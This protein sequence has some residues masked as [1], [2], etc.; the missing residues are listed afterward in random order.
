MPWFTTLIFLLFFFFLITMRNKD[1]GIDREGL[2]KQQES[3]RES[4][5][6]TDYK[7]T[8][9]KITSLAGWSCTH[10]VCQPIRAVEENPKQG[11]VLSKSVL[12]LIYQLHAVELLCSE[13]TSPEVVSK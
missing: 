2:V 12:P 11:S 4:L 6:R 1:V 10:V 5:S 13:C 3:I 7:N 9:L 8:F